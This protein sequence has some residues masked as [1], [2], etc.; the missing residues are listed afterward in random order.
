[1]ASYTLAN[2]IGADTTPFDLTAAYALTGSGYPGRVTCESETMYVTGGADTTSISVLRGKDGTDAAAHSAG[3]IVADA[4]LGSGGGAQTVSLLVYFEANGAVDTSSPGSGSVPVWDTVY[5][6]SQAEVAIPAALGLELALFG[7][8]AAADTALSA[9]E[10]G[11]WQFELMGAVTHDVTAR[12]DI[13]LHVSSD[14]SGG[15][16]VAVLA[17]EGGSPDGEGCLTT[18]VQLAEGDIVYVGFRLL[19]PAPTADPY[20]PFRYAVLKAMRLA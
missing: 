2:D 5:D 1:M 8:G 9:T 16:R 13:A 3:A 18:R 20:E 10:A 17:G 15:P 4:N 14:Y 19:A 11:E 12:V 7:V 6:V